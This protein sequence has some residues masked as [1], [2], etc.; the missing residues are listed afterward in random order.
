MLT[1]PVR[2]LTDEASLSRLHLLGTLL[3]VLGVALGTGMFF[4]WL[5][6]LEHQAVL[7][8]IKAS[9]QQQ[10]ERRLQ[11]ESDRTV[12]LI[13]YSAE[14]YEARLR[15]SLVQQVDGALAIAQAIH[16]AESPRRPAG[17]VQRLIKEALRGI[18]F[19]DGR[20]YYFIDDLQGRFILLPTAPQYEGRLL[21]DN[22]DDRGHYIM[23]G[24]IEAAG[25]PPGEGFSRYRW[26]RPDN[27]R[28]MADKLAYVRLFTPYNWLIGTGDY[29]HKWEELQQKQAIDYLRT[30]RFGDTG[31]VGLLDR[32]GRSLLSPSNEALEGLHLEEMPAAQRDVLRLIMAQA[33]HGGGLIHY[34]WPD[35]SGAVQPK[36]AVI[37]V[38]EP[39][40]WVLVT[41]MQDSE[42]A[43]WIDREIEAYAALDGQRIRALLLAAAVALLL[44]LPAAFFFWRWARH[45]F[46]RYHER[47]HAQA[48]T[49]AAQAAELRT[50][51]QVVEQ[52]PTSIM[53]TTPD[54]LITYVNPRFEQISGYS[55]AEMR[56]QHPR[57]LAAESAVAVDYHDMWETLRRGGVWAGEFYNRRKDG[58]TFWER[59]IIAPVLDETGQAAYFVALKED[60][61]AQKQAAE[62]LRQSEYRMA[63]ILD[64]VEAY[65]YIK[66][67]DYRY[68]YANHLVCE[69]FGQPREAIVGHRDEDFFDPLT[70]Q[71]INENDRRV[72]E[73]GA[74]VTDEEVNTLADGTV[75]RAY[76]STKIPLRDADGQVVALCGISTDMTQR[77]V[78][79][80]ELA[81]YR[82][83]LENL[84]AERTA[85]LALAK[86]QAE[87]ANRAK[88]AFL[89]NMSHEIR[90]PMNAIIGMTH[91]LLRD[92]PDARGQD[93]LGK[94]LQ[95]AQHL[96]RVINDI[97]DLSKIEAGRVHLDDSDFAP[98]DLVAQ[99]LR[100][101]EDE[102]QAKQITLKSRVDRDVPAYVC[103]DA[104]RIGQALINFLG[105]A[106]KFSER[107]E[108]V[109]QVQR[110]AASNAE[111]RLRFEVSDQGIGLS[112][113]AQAG[114]FEP[115]V[116]ADDS[117]TRRYGGTGLGLA[118]NRRLAEMMG[119]EV[120]V[121][122]EAGQGSRFWM[123]VALRPALSLAHRAEAAAAGDPAVQLAEHYAG[124]RVLL[125]EDEPV[126]QYVASEL[127]TDVGLRVDL[128]VNGAEALEMV[129]RAS[130]DLI[131][132][133]MQMPVMGGLE[134][135]RAIRRLPQGGALPI[136]AMTAN[137]FEEDRRAC[138][139][140]G[141]NDHVGKPVDPA[142]LYARI[143]HWLAAPALAS[144][145]KLNGSV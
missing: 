9:A 36:T 100:L 78:A 40:G 49:L 136:L 1:T 83:H 32:D 59:A 76:W 131:L 120:G 16:A 145:E 97:L 46:A 104:G 94:V 44:A 65:I 144:R 119:G 95:A 80:A 23:R 121:D 109:L 93:R 108:V 102:A 66:G 48:A 29:L 122:S 138:L 128:A 72:I 91:L 15:E 106:V 79:E 58:S 37:K 105:N 75:T 114:L 124:R 111:I 90:T 35:S 63:E 112:Q 96:L 71:K 73:Q 107:G 6:Q 70:T 20:G 64:T 22:Q 134:A 21:P 57:M 39:W 62:A 33:K 28:E 137:A 25:K 45:M 139:D 53:I 99:S 34:R 118:I 77:K 125:V 10:V 117:T 43:S 89:A 11:A 54:G 61:S 60:I 103:G 86:D 7:A 30:F 8:R 27:A 55:A 85:Q 2:P 31:Y 133:D 68:Q 4:S 5:S 88:S 142:V 56:G 141:M 67:T 3:V 69:L 17:D 87:A 113:E 14:R 140:A 82:G 24:L 84:V 98:A 50:L 116:Q 38:V 18:R 143:L 135:T 126:N 92:V 13:T 52:S 26:Y 74:R 123:T 127:L 42:A 41:T 81:H 110:Q 115:F 101:I 47:L 132:M 19:F 130:Y 51:S 129:G 12:N